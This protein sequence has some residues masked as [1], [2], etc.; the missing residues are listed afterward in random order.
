MQGKLADPNFFTIFVTLQGSYVFLPRRWLFM[1][2]NK[3]KIHIALLS[4]EY[5]NPS[6]PEGGLANYLRKVGKALTKGG[7][8]ISVFYLSDVKRHWQDEGGIQIYEV[9]SFKYPYQIKRLKLIAKLLPAFAQIRSAKRLEKKLWE[10]HSSDPIDII[11]ASSYQSPG[12]TLLN[13]GQIPLICRV[14]SY[15]P[16]L[17]SAEGIQRTFDQY[18]TDWLEIRQVADVQAAFAPSQLMVDTYARLE[19]CKLQVIRTPVER[20]DIEWDESLY[21]NLLSGR[22]YLLYFGTLKLVKGVDLLASIIEPLLKRYSDLSIAFVGRDDGLNNG[23]AIF[24][25]IVERNRAFRERLLYHPAVS[26]DKLYPIVAHAQAVL[27][28]SRV[29]N[30]P[31]ACLEAQT[32]G[33]PVIGTYDSSLDEMII[34][35][36]TGFLAENENSEAFLA[37]INRFLSLSS[38]QKEQMRARIRSNIDSIMAEDRVGKLIDLYR[39]TIAKFQTE[40]KH[41]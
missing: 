32:L 7:H 2:D 17:R 8:R 29:D 31:N 20:Q 10:I 6:K 33:V 37:A 22:D 35:G 16:L 28:P 15:R 5:S 39:E 21:M 30:Y 36:E 25:H 38:E 24:D 9:P 13:N 19:N 34:D 27:M 12:Y 3:N 41:L 11:Q 26:K 23:Q 40:R 4:P 14:S 18:L 1:N